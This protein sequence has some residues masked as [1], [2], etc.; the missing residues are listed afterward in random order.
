MFNHRLHTFSWL[1]AT[2]IGF[3][4]FLGSDKSNPQF[5]KC[6]VLNQALT[7]AEDDN[8]SDEARRSNTQV[9]DT[10]PDFRWP[11]WEQTDGNGSKH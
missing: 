11:Q 7:N 2:N 6:G 10:K 3:H 5:Q 1:L 4:D 9:I 8:K